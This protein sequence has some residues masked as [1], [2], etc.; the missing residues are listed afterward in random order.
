MNRGLIG[1]HIL[2]SFGFN[3]KQTELKKAEDGEHWVTINGKHVLLGGGGEVKSGNLKGEGGK[4][5][6]KIDNGPKSSHKGYGESGKS[7]KDGTEVR[8]MPGGG[9]HRVDAKTGKRVAEDIT[10]MNYKKTSSSDKSEF[11]IDDF[12][13]DIRNGNFKDLDSIKLSSNLNPNNKKIT[14]INVGGVNRMSGALKYSVQLEG[15]EDSIDNLTNSDFTSNNKSAKQEDKRNIR[16]NPIKSRDKI[17]KD[18][19]KNTFSADIDRRQ[20]NSNPIIDKYKDL[21][22]G[23][24]DLKQH[25][26]TG[27]EIEIGKVP[28]VVVG[29]TEGG[30][31]LELIN[32]QTGKRITAKT[33]EYNKYYPKDK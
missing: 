32:K 31:S 12:N 26:D 4:N 21:Y 14:S 15:E 27:R 23:H 20:S 30:K 16:T 5:I 29:T 6:D 7:N 2:N 19:D 13:E 11:N 18:T 3:Q 9:F 22:A 28:H 33:R 24:E 17:D 1:E 25:S 8:A 10:D